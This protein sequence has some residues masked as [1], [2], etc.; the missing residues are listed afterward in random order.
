M[1]NISITTGIC[2]LILAMLR[3]MRSQTL[4]NPEE[5]R[6]RIVSKA[7]DFIVNLNPKTNTASATAESIF[8]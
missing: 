3:G 8:T 2:F 1:K 5:E 4:V 6:D 7:R